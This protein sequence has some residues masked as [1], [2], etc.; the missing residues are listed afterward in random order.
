MGF[1]VFAILFQE[2]RSFWSFL[3]RLRISSD[4][5]FIFQ[6]ISSLFTTGGG[7][8]SSGG[9]NSPFR[10]AEGV[11]I[12]PPSWRGVRN[13]V[14]PRE[15]GTFSGGSFS[16][17]GIRREFLGDVSRK[18]LE[19]SRKEGRISVIFLSRRFSPTEFWKTKK[20][21]FSHATALP[22]PSARGILRKVFPREMLS[23]FLVS[24]PKLSVRRIG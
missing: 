17:R 10:I 9:I 24:F 1:R 11:I 13:G 8:W 16:L 22:F 3:A 7:C 21:V 5:I 14:F 19:R 12:F 15:G 20:R 4:Q 2:A 18:V 6:S 23:F